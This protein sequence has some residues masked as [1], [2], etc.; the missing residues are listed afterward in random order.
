MK[1]RIFTHL[2]AL[3]F[4]MALSLTSCDPEA[5]FNDSPSGSDDSCY[6]PESAR[7]RPEE[8]VLN[9]DSEYRMYGDSNPAEFTIAL[10]KEDIANG[11]TPV[12]F[13]SDGTELCRLEDNGVHP[14]FQARDGIYSCSYDVTSEDGQSRS[15]Y[16]QTGDKKTEELKML[17]F[18]ELTDAD[19]DRLKEVG[20]MF[21]EAVKDYTEDGY[22]TDPEKTLKAADKVAKKLY[23]S[24]EAVY[25]NYQPESGVINIKLDSGLTYLYTVKE[26]GTE[27]STISEAPDIRIITC[28]PTDETYPFFFKSVLKNPD[29]AAD[30]LDQEFNS[31]VF[32]ADNNDS[33]VTRG[34]VCS[35]TANQVILWQGHG[36][37]D[38]KVG[39]CAWLG[40]S[41]AI[42]E[43]KASYDYI[44]N[45]VVCAEDGRIGITS[46]FIDAHCG[47]LSNTL[48][49]MGCCESAKDSR[50]AQSFLDKGAALY[51]GNSNTIK[52]KYNNK[53]IRSF[54]D[55]LIQ[56]KGNT[57]NTA[58]QAL[59]Y[60]KKENGKYD[61]RKN[62]AEPL[63]F[64]DT[65][66]T[67]DQKY[68]DDHPVS[69]VT[70]VSGGWTDYISFEKIYI[71][72]KQG[73][74]VQLGIAHLPEGYNCYDPQSEDYSFIW[75]VENPS[76]AN[77]VSPGVFEGVSRGSTIICLHS[78]DLTYFCYCACTVY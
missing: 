69:E 34:L 32:T 11:T 47:N 25:Y 56:K 4:C 48:I 41:F 78:A 53:M 37:H 14:D 50:M 54:A 28:Q 55:G 68:I 63:L 20:E 29:Q 70:A 21:K 17:Y 46:K 39:S 24:G 23:E 38:E 42:D 10:S 31:A 15:F 26:K 43:T 12:L 8:N 3:T 16:V 40:E 62:K 35:F 59:K 60:A 18:D 71:S 51:V 27:G 67:M 13:S 57:H 72:I 7:Y 45:R 74:T 77:M 6:I 52:T 61:C 5:F 44:Y 9:V 58:Q 75:S 22:I 65:S 66:Y 64:G 76:I 73:E 1:K 33:A 30:A 49:Y 36:C 19:F 2:A